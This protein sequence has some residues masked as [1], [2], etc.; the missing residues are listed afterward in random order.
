MFDMPLFDI[1]TITKFEILAS[2]TVDGSRWYTI[3][4]RHRNDITKFLLDKEKSS[5]HMVVY[6]DSPWNGGNIYDVHESIYNILVLKYG[7]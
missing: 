5:P 2:A 7:I 4:I 6:V 1:S 3:H